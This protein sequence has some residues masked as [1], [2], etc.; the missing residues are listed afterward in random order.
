V[1]N[2]EEVIAQALIGRDA[3]DQVDID[4]AMLE[5]DGTANK[6]KLGAN[7]ILGVSWPPPSRRHGPRNCRSTATSAAPT[8]RSCPSR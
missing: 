2:V 1:S 5:L 4:H 6:K 3:A 7:A 8:P